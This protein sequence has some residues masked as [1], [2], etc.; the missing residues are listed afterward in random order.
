MFTTRKRR[1]P[2]YMGKTGLQ[3]KSVMLT[4]S[5]GDDASRHTYKMVDN[6]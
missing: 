6:T 5:I 1:L 3:N 4:R 2:S